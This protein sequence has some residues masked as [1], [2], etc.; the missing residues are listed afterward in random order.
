MSKSNM[1]FCILSIILIHYSLFTIHYSQLRSSTADGVKASRGLTEG[2]EGEA[3]RRASAT[4]PP[5]ISCTS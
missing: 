4:K 5:P 3:R 1:K 2:V